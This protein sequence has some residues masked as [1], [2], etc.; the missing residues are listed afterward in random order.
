MENKINNSFILALSVSLSIKLILSISIPITGDEAYFVVWAKNLDFGYYDHPPMIGWILHFLLYIGDQTFLLRLPAVLSTIFIGFCIYWLLKPY[1]KTKAYLLAILFLVSPIN[2][3]NIII[4]NDTPA[5]IFSFLSV[6]FL[7]YALKKNKLYMYFL[8]GICLGCSFLSKYFAVLLGVSFL[9]YFIFTEKKKEKLIGFLILYVSLIPFVVLN[10]YWNY[11][12]GWTNLLFNFY[13]RNRGVSFSFS[14]SNIS[15]FFIMQ[16]Y[17]FTPP[18]VYYLYKER[19][20]FVVHFRNKKFH[21]FLF[22]FFIPMSLFAVLSTQ[23]S[24]GLHWVISF[25]PFLY[26]LLYMVL[27]EDQVLKSI[28]GMIIFSIVH[29]LIIV[30]ALSLPHDLLKNNKYYNTIV[31]GFNPNKVL[32][33]IKLY[34]QDYHL[35]SNSYATAAMLGYFH[36]RNFSV[37]GS[38]SIHGRQDD[39]ITNYKEFNN[40][41]ILIFLKR[42]PLKEDYKKY[43]HDVEIKNFNLKGAVFHFVLGKKFNYEVYRDVVLEEIK[44]K[45]YSIPDYFPCKSSYFYEKYFPKETF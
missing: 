5:L 15:S 16:L 10:F 25:Y 3:L 9:T 6:F 37:F 39:M 35:S 41:N 21:I 32:S 36:K 24:V 44:K 22:V 13:H 38:G 7:F 4:T 33:Y 1:D 45:Y 20:Q 30:I 12:H 2:I 42:A 19:S 31:L 40:E 43:F 28:K 17:L 29:L 11:T 14:F 23:R 34:E 27:N 18:I 26:I 8:S